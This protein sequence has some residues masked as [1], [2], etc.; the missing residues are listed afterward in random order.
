MMKPCEQRI[1]NA[2]GMVI[3]FLSLTALVMVLTGYLQ[4]P[5]PDEGPAAHIFQLCIVALVPMVLLF[6]ATAD[7]SRPL[8]SARRLVLPAVALIL[9]FSALYYLEHYRDPNYVGAQATSL[10]KA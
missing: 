3:L 6:V 1:N 7:R 2:S 5:Q 9:A 8:R 4:P 10:A